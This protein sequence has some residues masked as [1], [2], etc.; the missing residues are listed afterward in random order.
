MGGL[1]EEQF[2]KG[3]WSGQGRV[4]GVFLGEIVVPKP[5]ASVLLTGQSQK[6]IY[7]RFKV[8]TYMFWVTN[9]FSRGWY[10]MTRQNKFE[11]H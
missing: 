3:L 1:L 7:K 8:R 2:N 4:V 11:E 6:Y 5:S 9:V 10:K